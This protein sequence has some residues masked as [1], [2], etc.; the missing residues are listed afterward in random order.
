MVTSKTKKLGTKEIEDLR[1]LKY[2]PGRVNG[3]W[4]GTL[5]G[6]VNMLKF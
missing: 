2:G 6:Y 1:L 4:V 5:V 3:K